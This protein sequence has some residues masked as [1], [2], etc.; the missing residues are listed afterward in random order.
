MIIYYIIAMILIG[1]D[2]L[3]KY[4]TVQEI[5]LG[6]VVPVIPNVLSLTYIRN[7]GAA[8]SIL[9]DQMIFF[10]V[11]TVVVVGALIYFLHTEGK[12]S[13]IASTGIA[14]IMGGA[15]G[16]FI[17]RL[18]LKYVIDMIRLEFINFPIF[19]V[20]DMALTIGVIILIGYIVYDE[21]V[22]KKVKGS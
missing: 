17:D 22:K 11:I 1:L 21:L 3:S 7:S 18:H 15:I 20:A 19:N 12:R 6:E 5:A 8:W 14:F 2:Q 4:L 16:N 10:Y 13:P 9:E